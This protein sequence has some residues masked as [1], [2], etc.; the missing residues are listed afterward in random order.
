MT[1]LP[2]GSGAIV[3]VGSF[4][5]VHRGH[6]AVLEQIARRASTAGLRSVLV[7]FDPHPLEVV[8]PAAAP[9]LLTD[10]SEKLE[11]LAQ[12]AV[13]AVVVLR[14][15]PAVAAMSPREFVRD[16]L[17]ARCRMRELVIGHD[18]GFGRGRSGNA[19]TLRGLSSALGF[20][21]QVVEPV[22]AEGGAVSSSRIR[23]MVGE[24]DLHG[25]SRL[26]GRAY[27][28]GGVVVEGA[29]RGRGIG[30][31][32][33]NV[34]GVSPRKQLPPDGVYAVRVETPFGRFDGMMNQGSRPTVGDMA[35]TLE[36]HLFGFSGDLYGRRV[37]VEWVAKIR[38]VR[39]FASLDELKLQ[40]AHD[41][42]GAEALLA[43]P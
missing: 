37:R 24:G 5:G 11:A 14:F 8:R 2:S 38:E 15:G 3:T 17:I 32:T 35:R 21:L 18:H 22:G 27:S 42:A 12:T 4:D 13:E 6:H 10:R 26:L 20:G 29:R 36:A 31:P 34:G 9:P 16:I 7:T 30:V 40:L 43:R 19:E 23:Q 41:R 33:A 28:V 39:S 25:A 1:A